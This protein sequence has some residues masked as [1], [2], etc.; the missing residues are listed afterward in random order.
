MKRHLMAEQ[1]AK[2]AVAVL[3]QDASVIQ[4][5]EMKRAFYAGAQAIMFKVIAA[6]A[7]EEEPTEAD[8][9]MMSDLE[10]ELQDFAAM[11]KAGQA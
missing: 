1:W 3:P 2:F 7:P 9:Q 8:L 10:Q 4:R 5:R 11:V 6:L